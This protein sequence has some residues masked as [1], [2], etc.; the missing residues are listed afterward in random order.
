MQRRAGRRQL[1]RGA[2]Q[3]GGGGGSFTGAPGQ[4]GVGGEPLQGDPGE[5]CGHLPGDLLPGDCAASP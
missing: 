1:W 5:E 2:P 4:A 3:G